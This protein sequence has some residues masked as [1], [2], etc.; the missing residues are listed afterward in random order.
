MQTVILGLALCLMTREPAV[1]GIVVDA[2]GDP[3]TAATVYVVHPSD[4]AQDQSVETDQRG[5]FQLD[6]SGGEYQLLAVRPGYAA[7]AYRKRVRTFSWE[8]S[9]LSSTGIRL[10]LGPVN[11]RVIRIV[12]PDG[13]PVAGASV[14][15]SAIGNGSEYVQ[16]RNGLPRELALQTDSDGRVDVGQ[17]AGSGT[18]YLIVETDSHGRQ[19]FP[20]PETPGDKPET[21]QL[22]E[23]GTLTGEFVCDDASECAGWEI[24]TYPQSTNVPGDGIT[25][26]AVES[27]VTDAKGNFKI[28]QHAAGTYRFSISR[29]ET[30]RYWPS[31]PNEM[32]VVAGQ[33]SQIQFSLQ[34]GKRAF[35]QLI[36]RDSE[37][38]I[39]GVTVQVGGM[40]ATSGPDGVFE[41]F[42]SQPPQYL[43]ISGAVPGYVMPRMFHRQVQAA[44]AE[45]EE[46]D[47]GTVRLKKA[48]PVTGTV[49]DAG[50]EP[51]PGITVSAAWVQHD[52]EGFNTFSWAS[53]TAQTDAEGRYQ[54]DG[55]PGDESLRITAYGRDMATESAQRLQP[56]EERR[57]DLQVSMNHAAVISVN[58]TDEQGNPIAATAQFSHSLETPDKG[59]L[60]SRRISFSGRNVVSGDGQGVIRSP[61]VLP[62]AERYSLEVKADGYLPRT[63]EFTH[64]EGRGETA[65]LGTVRLTRARVATGIVVDTSGQPVSGATAAAHGIP[66]NKYSPQ[67]VVTQTTGPDG[68]FEL[69]PLHP[70]SAVVTVSADGYRPSG[71]VLR[72]Q[73]AEAVITLTRSDEAVPEPH[74]IGLPQKSNQ[75]T[76]AGIYLLEEMMPD[77]RNSNYFNSQALQLLGQVS[78]DRI[79]QVLSSIKQPSA[80]VDA[81]LALGE[82]EEADAQ[83]EQ[84]NDGYGRGYAR[85]RIID[86]ATDPSVARQLIASALL[87]AR[88]IQRPDRRAVVLAGVAERLTVLGELTAAESLL[89]DSLEEFQQLPSKEWAGFA[90]GFFAERLARYD[91][92][93]AVGLLGGMEPDDRA[94]HAGNIAHVLAAVDPEKAESLMVD[95]DATRSVIAYRIRACYRMASVDLERA[96]RI[97]E[98]YSPRTSNYAKQHTLGVMAM[99]V[100]DLQLARELLDRAWNELETAARTPSGTV[101]AGR[102]RF[103][104]A[105]ALLQYSEKIDPENL[106]DYFWRAIAMYPGPRGEVRKPEQQEVEDLERRA[107]LV[108]PFATYSVE[109]D[110]CREQI[111]P[112]FDY[113]SDEAHLKTHD[114]YRKSAT[115]S[116][117][118]MADPRRAAEWARLAYQSMPAENRRL[119]PQPWLTVAI[120]LCADRDVVEEMLAEE[121]FTRWFI[122]KYDL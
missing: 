67:P 87:D 36:E 112:A 7:G 114:F 74:R 44:D 16:R 77:I 100:E 18:A 109:P 55:T 98:G 17:F 39:A 28:D 32:T 46:L 50:G 6:M 116:A 42:V 57:V 82:F 21:V 12:S 31:A 107:M 102:Y 2:Q 91:F 110:W 84:I 22:A 10:Q 40:S 56:G 75:R 45:A 65:T 122:D 63:T 79:P 73:D 11:S 58:V 103:G 118:A 120:T 81:L 49:T 37:Q 76:A 70:H 38:P 53:D 19:G 113:W 34:P 101:Q 72:S 90:K 20:L 15:P 92:E 69:S 30:S 108:L 9:R 41:A 96:E 115:F 33:E 26:F 64:P 119:I 3:V 89:R 25:T 60:G 66:V 4:P 47:V 106:T 94:R 97:R 27:A 52:D 104:V 83:V 29:R 61:H 54:L 71:A 8:V 111:G 62:R 68:R 24:I 1:T 85:F 86:A 48:S 78:P 105:L 35:G 43:S 93:A 59:S 95:A 121:V 117:M 14:V 88:S 80:R 5:Q 99:A 23:V 13:H 51:L